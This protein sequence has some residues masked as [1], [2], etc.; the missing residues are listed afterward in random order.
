MKVIFEDSKE[1]VPSQFLRLACPDLFEFSGGG[2]NLKN[3]LDGLYKEGQV[4][5]VCVDTIPD[6]EQ[7]IRQLVGVVQHIKEK[8]YKGVYVIPIPCI[9]YYIIKAF[10]DENNIEVRNVINLSDY[11]NSELNRRIY[12]GRCPSFEKYCK[13][14]A[15]HILKFCRR[16]GSG[17]E[18]LFYLVDCLCEKAEIAGCTVEITRLQKAWELVKTLPV[19]ETNSS[20]TYFKTRRVGIRD[21]QVQQVDMYNILCH[22]LGC[23][24]YLKLSDLITG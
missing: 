15:L 11:S 10:G 21:I 14:V 7:T 12:R 22:N 17:R 5:A 18:G 20:N 23:T 2:R 13:Q 24:N 19:Y 1:A 8:R 6:N 3:K 16:V 4:F 9:E